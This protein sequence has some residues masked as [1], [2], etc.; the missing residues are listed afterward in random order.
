MRFLLALPAIFL[1][2]ACSAPAPEEAQKAY[3]E[4]TAKLIR[5][6]LTDRFSKDV[7]ESFRA[8]MTEFLTA[9]PPAPE[10]AY[11][12]LDEELNKLVTEDIEDLVSALI[13]IYTKHFNHEDVRQLVAFYESDLGQK[14]MMVTPQIAAESRQEVRLWSENFGEVLMGRMTERFAKE[15]IDV[16]K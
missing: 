8:Q 12:I 3:Q 7:A 14:V 16:S 15:E 5:I 10:R 2:L 13:P 6:S 9:D 11:V 4:D 1:L